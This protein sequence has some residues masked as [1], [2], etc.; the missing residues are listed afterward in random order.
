MKSYGRVVAMCHIEIDFI[1][2]SRLYCNWSTPDIIYHSGVV[3][4][5]VVHRDLSGGRVAAWCC[6]DP[7]NISIGIINCEIN[8]RRSRFKAFKNRNDG[9]SHDPEWL[10]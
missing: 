6:S 5:I 2:T 1:N 7:G 8:K 10:H 9:W 3:N 4:I